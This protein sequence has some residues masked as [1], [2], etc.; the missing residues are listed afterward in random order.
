M[1]RRSAA[2]SLPSVKIRMTG[3]MTSRIITDIITVHTASAVHGIGAGI[4]ARIGVR[5]DTAHGDTTGGMTRS[6][7]EV[8]M[9]RGTMEAT[10]THG[11]EDTGDITTLGIMATDGILTITTITT[12]DGTADGIHTMVRD[13]STEGTATRKTNG[14]VSA[15]RQDQREYSQA[16]YPAVEAQAQEAV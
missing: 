14:M 10:T 16:V 1:T 9:T 13:I 2:Q 6:T 12:A 15:E 8:G 11:T 4:T 7:S 3:D 5:G